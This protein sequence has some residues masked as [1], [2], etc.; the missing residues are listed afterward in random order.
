M[1]EFLEW[2]DIKDVLEAGIIDADTMTLIVEYR[3]E[4]F[5][6]GAM[7]RHSRACQSRTLTLEGVDD[8][9]QNWDPVAEQEKLMPCMLTKKILHRR[10]ET[11]AKDV[12]AQASWGSWESG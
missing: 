2:D 9:V 7:A 10:R 8:S 1:E 5:D 4:G 11:N 6:D 3:G 12:W